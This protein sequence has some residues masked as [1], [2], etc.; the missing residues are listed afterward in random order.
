MLNFQTRFEDGGFKVDYR[1]TWSCNWS[2][3]STGKFLKSNHVKN[4]A[5]IY[6]IHV[7]R[8]ESWQTHF[9]STNRTFLF[10]KHICHQFTAL[11]LKGNDMLSPYQ[12]QCLTCTC[13]I[14]NSPQ[15][16]GPQAIICSSSGLH[17]KY[18]TPY[19]CPSRVR[20]TDGLAP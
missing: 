3:N 13:H 4:N 7:N 2:Y 16:S 14:H 11:P 19:K 8:Y 12:D 17:M 15:S 6:C 18:D 20:K 9:P 10:L 5:R 1:S